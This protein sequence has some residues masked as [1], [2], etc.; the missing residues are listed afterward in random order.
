MKFSGKKFLVQT[1]AGPNCGIHEAGLVKGIIRSVK[2]FSS[3][4][5]NKIIVARFEV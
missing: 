5:S 4:K 2:S 1:R 3:A